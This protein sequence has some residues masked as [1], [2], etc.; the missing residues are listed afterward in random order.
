MYDLLNRWLASACFATL[1]KWLNAWGADLA[2]APVKLGAGP[3]PRALFWCSIVG[4][5]QLPTATPKY[6]KSPL[7]LGTGHADHELS[8][9]ATI[10]AADDVRLY[11]LRNL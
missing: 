6:A 7:L 8:V 5:G 9:C 1:N 4:R 2:R 3:K 11:W 10:S